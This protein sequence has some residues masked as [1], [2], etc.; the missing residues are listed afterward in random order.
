M[1]KKLPKN[2]RSSKKYES[3]LEPQ[4]TI[5][6]G[7]LLWH[8]LM[9]SSSIILGAMSYGFSSIVG[10]VSSSVHIDEEHWTIPRW[11]LPEWSG[12]NIE[13]GWIC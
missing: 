9:L 10:I 3:L 13:R 4:Q 7:I 12:S 1:L 2:F 11:I 6:T 5:E 8:W